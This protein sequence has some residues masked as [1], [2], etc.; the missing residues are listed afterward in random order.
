M[1]CI[2]NSKILQ[3]S[4]YLPHLTITKYKFM[5]NKLKY[6]NKKKNERNNNNRLPR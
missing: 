4:K 6:N 3:A 5:Y 2:L 1:Q